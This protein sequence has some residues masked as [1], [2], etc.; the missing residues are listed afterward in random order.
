MYIITPWKEER[1]RRR[2]KGIEASRL[3]R[4]YVT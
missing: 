3:A 2:S 4:A 1:A